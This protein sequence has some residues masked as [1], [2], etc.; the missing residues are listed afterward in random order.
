LWLSRFALSQGHSIN[1]ASLFSIT[2]GDLF[3]TRT[4][5]HRC[6]YQLRESAH[7]HCVCKFYVLRSYKFLNASSNA[8]LFLLY[9]HYI[10]YYSS[11]AARAISM[12]KLINANL[13]TSSLVM[14]HFYIRI[15]LI[16]N[17]QPNPK[18]TFNS[19]ILL[20]CDINSNF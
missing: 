18:L 4:S 17:H 14:R 8:L 13:S 7:F 10:Y 11:L 15:I 5:L 6:Y 16:T 12:L 2:G 9:Y 19:S 20:I 3:N 1:N